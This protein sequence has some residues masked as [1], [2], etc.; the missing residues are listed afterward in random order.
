MSLRFHDVAPPAPSAAA[1]AAAGVDACNT[2]SLTMVGSYVYSHET[3][4]AG[5]Y[6]FDA[7]PVQM[8]KDARPAPSTP[9]PSGA[10]M[11]MAERAALV[12]LAHSTGV[13]GW[14][15]RAGWLTDAHVCDW[16]LVGCD[17]ERRVKVLALD[18]NGL[19]GTLPAT[20]GALQNLQDLDLEHN[21]LHGTLPGA[22]G[23]LPALAQL[24][25]GG[26]AFSGVVP[27]ELCAPLARIRGAGLASSARSARRHAAGGK[28]QGQKPCDLSGLNLACPLPC[29]SLTGD[30]CGATC[31]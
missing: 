6:A 15:R 29:A 23:A 24:G 27:A 14:S 3:S 21:S 22:L 20:L 30:M 5:I 9:P 28:G 11:E 2:G 1:A 13:H 4:D 7:T 26:N 25:L 19:N 8:A 10:Q 31:V 18:F 16:E 17:A 12:E